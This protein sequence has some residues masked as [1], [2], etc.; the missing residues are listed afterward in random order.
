MKTSTQVQEAIETWRSLAMK[1][2]LTEREAGVMERSEKTILRTAV[3]D[4]T[5]ASAICDVVLYNMGPG[6]RTDQ[7]E[8]KA[9]ESL[10]LWIAQ[11]P[12]AAP[13]RPISSLQ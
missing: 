9:I 8:V 7:S 6:G 11:T 5:H 2:D 4:R 1:S 10:R 12:V 13:A 3:W